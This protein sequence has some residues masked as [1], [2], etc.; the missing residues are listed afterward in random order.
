MSTPTI[1]P[2]IEATVILAG[3]KNGKRMRLLRIEGDGCYTFADP[4]NGNLRTVH[5]DRVKQ[6]HHKHRLEKR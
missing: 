4:R 2:G 3:R 5:P 1:R 6:W